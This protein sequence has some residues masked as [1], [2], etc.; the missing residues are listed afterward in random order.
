[1]EKEYKQH[2]AEGGASDELKFS[3]AWHLIKS[4]YKNDIRKGIRM[5]ESEIS[6]GKDQR[7]YFYFIALGHY[8][9]EEYESAE[10]CVDRVLLMEHNNYQAKQLKELIVKKLRRDGLLGMGIL[11]GAVLVG[12]ALAAGAVALAG[13]GIA[14]LAKKMSCSI[15]IYHHCITL[16]FSSYSK[17]IIVTVY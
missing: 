15:F 10:R 5:M 16:S 7:D 8:K 12:G 17:I 2:V 3:Y 1:V 13:M 9:L 4:S 14:K 11:G 6:Q